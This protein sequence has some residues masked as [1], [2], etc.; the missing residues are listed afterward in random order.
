MQIYGESLCSD[1]PYKTLLLSVSDSAAAV[2][3]EML[4]KY[5][6]YREDPADFCLVQ[7]SPAALPEAT[8]GVRPAFGGTFWLRCC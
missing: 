1:V 8:G 7:V 5:G 6:K 3:V 2:V 4:Q